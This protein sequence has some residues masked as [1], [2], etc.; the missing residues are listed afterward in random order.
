MTTWRVLCDFD[1][2]IANEDVIDALLHQFGR[3]GWTELESAWRA[4]RIGSRECLAGQTALLAMTR[5][6]FEAHV[7]R[8]GIDADFPAFA[9]GLAEQAIPLTIVSDGFHSAIAA[10]LARY[11]LDYL[12]IVANELQPAGR[13]WQLG[14]SNGAAGCASGTCKCEVAKLASVDARVLM[15]GDGASDFC[16]SQQSD[17]VFAKGRLAAHCRATARAHVEV[18]N[19]AEIN[20][21]LPVLVKYGAEATIEAARFLQHEPLSGAQLYA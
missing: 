2:T 6:Q 12:K 8:V 5:A 18:R 11:G 7:A 17:F 9:T 19:F 15:I 20:R 3:Q 1:G 16:V 21:L 4:G 14:S 13:G 10:I